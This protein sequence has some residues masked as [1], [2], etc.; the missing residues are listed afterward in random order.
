MSIL[1]VS[2]G[3]TVSIYGYFI[4]ILR[5]L[6]V[7]QLK[8]NGAV[9]SW[10]TSCEELYLKGLYSLSLIFCLAHCQPIGQNSVLFKLMEVRL[11][12]I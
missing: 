4:F 6:K 8:E 12:K 11:I 9:A 3:C 1:K 10:P 2:S 7:E 5:C